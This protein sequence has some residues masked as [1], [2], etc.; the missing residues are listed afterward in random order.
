MYQ[1]MVWTWGREHQL[2]AVEYWAEDSIQKQKPDD[3][4]ELDTIELLFQQSL[5]DS[6]PYTYFACITY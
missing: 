1:T 4:G 3:Y 6:M 2:K 5:G